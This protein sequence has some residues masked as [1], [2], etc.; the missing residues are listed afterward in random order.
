MAKT[1]GLFLYDRF[2]LLDASGPITAFEI[3]ERIVPGSYRLAVLSIDGGL[4]RSSSG[5]I[6][7][8]TPTEPHSLPDTLIVVGGLGA[9]AAGQC[10][11][12]IA[13]L[14]SCAAD[15]R[16]VCSVCSG[17]F[18]LGAAGLLD[19][20]RVTTHWR[21][22]RELQKMYPTARVEPDK[23]YVHDANFW[24]SGGVSAGVD[25]ALALIAQD[26]G[27]RVA[28]RVAQEMVVYFRRPGGQSQ[29]SVL[30]ELSDGDTDFSALLSWIR[31]HLSEELSVDQLA[32]QVAM[33]PR[34]FS[35]TFAK[36]MGITPA[37]AVER[38]RLETARERIEYSR[39]LVSEIAASTGFKDIETMRRSFLR[40]YGRTPQ[41][42]RRAG[43]QS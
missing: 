20:R 19:G 11:R 15:Q 27:D 14:R 18:L 28:Q 23:I 40:I 35:R 42:M 7:Q 38:L 3:A 32:S 29:F 2:Q 22:A 5:V 12:S 13:Y 41:E 24:T 43:H 39:H 16:R 4:L 1:V 21:V 6:L 25:L 17:T 9:Q 26:C 30:A 10:P 8:S 37:K 33:S 34:N 36:A 31:A